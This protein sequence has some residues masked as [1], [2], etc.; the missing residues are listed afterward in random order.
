V[1]TTVDIPV[2]LAENWL[3]VLSNTG[4]NAV[5]AC[6]ISRSPRGVA[7]G[8]AVAAP[9][10]IPLAAAGAVEIEGTAEPIT[11]LRLTLT[12]TLGT[13]VLIDGGGR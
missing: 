9:S 5:T 1:A 7:F 8:P 11:T 2:D 13:T 4:A 10:G 6:L 3:F 12:S